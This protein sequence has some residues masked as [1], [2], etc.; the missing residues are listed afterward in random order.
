MAAETKT[1]DSAKLV[2]QMHSYAA[3]TQTS[4]DLRKK[5]YDALMEAPVEVFGKDILSSAT[6]AAGLAEELFPFV[7]EV[8]DEVMEKRDVCPECRVET[9]KM[10]ERLDAD[11][12]YFA[13]RDPECP[14]VAASIR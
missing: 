11:M 2:R 6:E 14:G 5:L 4:L 13:C 9:M 8:I 3:H 12:I 10:D 7:R 1:I